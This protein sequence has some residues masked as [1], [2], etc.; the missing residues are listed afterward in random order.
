VGIDVV[1][2]NCENQN[3]TILTAGDAQAQQ[4]LES[5]PGR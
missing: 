5:L 1:A 2:N 4:E 3:P